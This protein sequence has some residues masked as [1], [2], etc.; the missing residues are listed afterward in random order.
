MH[1]WNLSTVLCKAL[2]AIWTGI[3]AMTR[4][5]RCI[6]SSELRCLLTQT[7]S[8]TMP[9]S[10]TQHGVWLDE[11][12]EHGRGKRPTS[13]NPR[14][15][16][17]VV[18]VISIHQTIMARDV[19]LLKVPPLENGKGYVLHHE[20]AEHGKVILS[21]DTM[22][23]KKRG[24]QSLQ[25]CPRHTKRLLWGNLECVLELHSGAWSSRWHS[26]VV[27]MTADVECCFNRKDEENVRL[28][29]HHFQVNLC[30]THTCL[31][32]RVWATAQYSYVISGMASFLHH[33][34]R[35]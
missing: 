21:P 3:P 17:R 19:V 20:P 25:I 26:C 13:T 28:H 5:R 27:H 32:V 29:M 23:F 18:L 15:T 14:F 11:R 9:Y 30:S 16:K 35:F 33:D 22:F 6:G 24:I 31:I 8:F 10:Q 12:T 1:L 4:V 2:W 7:R 34:A